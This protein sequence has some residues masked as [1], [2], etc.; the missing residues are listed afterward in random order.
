MCLTLGAA[1]SAIREN[2][3]KDVEGYRRAMLGRAM[4]L[5]RD[6]N[7]AEDLVQSA[8]LDA[9]RLDV[10]VPDEETLY[11]LFSLIS[12]RWFN[13][14]RRQKTRAGTIS[15]DDLAPSVD[16][17]Q[18]LSVR[19]A[20]HTHAELSEAKREMDK[21]EPF[22]QSVL[23]LRAV[24]F[25]DNEIAKRLGVNRKTVKRHADLAISSLR[26]TL[27]RGDLM[28]ASP[29]GRS[30]FRGVSKTGPSWQ[31]Y[32]G[33]G[34][35]RLYLG[36]HETPE[37]AALAVDLAAL[38]R[39]GDQAPLNFPELRGELQ[40]RLDAGENPAERQGRA[41]G[42]VHRNQKLIAADI[43]EIRKR[44]AAGEPQKAIAQDYGVHFNVISEIKRGT[45]WA[46]VP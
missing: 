17:I 21:L 15:A 14:R 13:E 20:Q 11:F 37:E 6:A 2:V 23:G 8:F 9:L 10:E 43:P 36:L 28:R 45:R 40:G 24:E 29:R 33:V 32:Q 3:R 31:A 44:I 26:K 25:T 34:H 41:D 16:F 27:G 22:Q 1:V 19:A 46:H 18:S 39:L 4:V 30:G 35:D 7:V 38:W 12:H 42:K 5:A